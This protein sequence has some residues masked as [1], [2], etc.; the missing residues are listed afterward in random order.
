MD[1]SGK[2]EIRKL[3]RERFKGLGADEL[4]RQSA[5]VW[6]AV[7][8]LD[9]FRRAHGVLAYWAMAD[10]VQTQQFILRWCGEKQFY[11]P[12][13]NGNELEIRPFAGLSDLR[14]GPGYGIPEPT[15]KPL[16]DLSC[17]D[18]ILVPGRAFDTRCNRLGRGK[19]YYDRLLAET[20]AFTLGI[21]IEF[22]LI[23]N[24]P[25][26]NHDRQLNAVVC[27]TRIFTSL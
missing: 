2:I 3:I 19:G 1:N 15:G 26:E 10:E 4:A 18:L 13:I 21:G 27:G 9:V 7:E 14:E 16:Q 5:Q 6:Q 24:V 23:E 20:D 12:S 25:T 22:Q 11:L 17:I 8:E